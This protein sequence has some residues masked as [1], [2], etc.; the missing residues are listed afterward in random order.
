MLPGSA[1]CAPA[2]RD[3]RAAALE[4]AAAEIQEYTGVAQVVFE[5]GEEWFDPTVASFHVVLDEGASGE[6]AAVV[7]RAYLDV[8]DQA[9]LPEAIL[10]FDVHRGSDSFSPVGGVGALSADVLE[11]ELH[12]WTELSV[13]GRV[14]YVVGEPQRAGVAG[15][16]VTVQLGGAAPLADVEQNVRKQFQDEFATRVSLAI[17]DRRCWFAMNDPDGDDHDTCPG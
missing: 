16:I 7:V 10:N 15:R 6:Q 8:V 9:S 13:L 12:S 5:L 17:L 14:H 4:E 2:A 1:A 11:R 3:P